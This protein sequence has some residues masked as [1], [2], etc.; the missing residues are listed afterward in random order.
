MSF[1]RIAVIAVVGLIPLCG[2]EPG[3]S[4]VS[5]SAIAPAPLAAHAQ[6][7][8][9][10]PWGA[11]DQRGSANR[12]TPERVAA[13]ADLITQG[14]IYP[15]GRAYE[16]GMPMFG[17]RHMSL[18]IPGAP[19]GGPLGANRIVYH[20]EMFTGEIGQIGT[21]LDALCHIAIRDESGEDVFYNGF[22]GADIRTPYGFTKLGVEQAGVFFCRGVLIDVPRF[23]GVE[24][25]EDGAVITSEELQG[26]LAAQGVD[27]REGDAVFIRTGH[28]R[29]WMTDNERYAAGEPGPGLSAIKWLIDKKIVLVGADN[30]AVEAIPGEHPDRPFECHEWLIQRNGIY[31]LENLNLDALAADRVWEFAFVFAPVPIKGATGSPGNPIALR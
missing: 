21:Q 17:A 20:D 28:G 18:T 29:L 8:Q 2:C 22:R 30:W 27:I 7:P 10:S 9:S 6:P 11:D 19:T 31:N 13:A 26:A 15:L 12:I 5:M 3:R 23:K 24:F 4:V 16:P 14:R 25:L 1:T